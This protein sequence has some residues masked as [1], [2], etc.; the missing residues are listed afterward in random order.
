MKIPAIEIQ[1]SGH[2]LYLAK[3]TAEQILACCYTAEWDPAFGWDLTQQGYQRAPV[4]S[5]YQAIGH[6]LKDNP[7][8]FL[9]TSALLSARESE[10]GKLHFTTL[11]SSG[12][13]KLV[14]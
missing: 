11:V 3:M 7:K 9:P 4:E 6:F 8:V 13:A 1:Q 10:T 12:D 5:H 14:S 2:V